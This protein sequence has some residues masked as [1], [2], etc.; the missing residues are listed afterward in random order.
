MRALTAGAGLLL[1]LG[2]SDSRPNVRA[3]PMFLKGQEWPAFVV[4]CTNVSETAQSKLD[5]ICNSQAFRLDGELHERQGIAGS[6]IGSAEIPVGATFT[7]V[8]LLGEGPHQP[9]S[10]GTLYGEYVVASLDARV[11]PGEHRV[12]FRCRSE[13]SD[14]MRFVWSGP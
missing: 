5:Y 8:V 6:F 7:Q 3:T 14:E 2:T 11:T 13:W 10:L 9:L 1:L 4:Q 12:A